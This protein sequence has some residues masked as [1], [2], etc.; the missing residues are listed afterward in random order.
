MYRKDG[1]N[2]NR[3][4][5]ERRK[6]DDYKAG[7]EMNKL[8]PSEFGKCSLRS[9]ASGP[10]WIVELMYEGS[11][12]LPAASVTSTTPTRPLSADCWIR[13]ESTIVHAARWY[14]TRR[15]M[16]PIAVVGLV[17]SRSLIGIFRNFEFNLHN[18]QWA[19]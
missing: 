7:N 18:F 14:R 8:P 12:L 16:P 17:I 5:D 19:R 1:M 2:T 6:V 10:L 11:L 15:E 4:T 9:H 3:Y 13:V